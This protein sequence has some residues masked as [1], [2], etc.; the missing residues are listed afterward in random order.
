MSEVFYNTP[1]QIDLRKQR[2]LH[3][4]RYFA[5]N[6][7]Y[8]GKIKLFKLL[9][10]LDFQHVAETGKPVTGLDYEAWKF[11]PVPVQVMEMWED[12]ENG[13]VEGCYV[14]PER[15]HDFVRQTIKVAP[16]AS[17]DENLFSRR[18]L[19]IMREMA[20]RYRQTASPEMIDV[21]HQENGAWD[22]VWQNGKGAFKPIPYALA[23]PEESPAASIL[24]EIQQD[25]QSRQ[26][27][28]QNIS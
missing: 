28:L 27:A 4:I 17:F 15:V 14:C 1:M 8:C 5:R 25:Y 6:T 19:R 26:K 24:L 16:D 23:I 22:K 18:E 2:V 12:L 10:L 3:A 9:Y 21:T 11:G 13:T 20:E 7:E